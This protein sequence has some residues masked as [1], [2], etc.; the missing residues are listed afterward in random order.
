MSKPLFDP[1]PIIADYEAAYR[2]A[3]NRE[4]PPIHYENG[5]FVFR[6]LF[7]ARNAYRRQAMIGM[8]GKLAK[9]AKDKD[10]D[11]YLSGFIRCAQT[12]Y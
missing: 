7:E 12:R 1:A 11:D 2:A 3:N 4:P 5:W 9:R 8:T 10:G 6:S